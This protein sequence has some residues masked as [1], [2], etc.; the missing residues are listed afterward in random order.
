PARVEGGAEEA[1]GVAGIADASGR[2]AQILELCI[3][4]GDWRPRPEAGW[5]VEEGAALARHRIFVAAAEVESG[6]RR[7][8]PERPFDGH[9]GMIAVDDDPR[10]VRATQPGQLL[11]QLED[12]AAAE[13]HMADEDQVVPAGC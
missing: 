7:L 13:Q 4:S 9:E 1:A 3:P 10:A 11:H 6:A 8:F 5:R 12:P 2:Q